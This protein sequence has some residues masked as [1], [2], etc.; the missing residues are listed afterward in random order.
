[1]SIGQKVVTTYLLG[2]AAYGFYRGWNSLCGWESLDKQSL[3]MDRFINGV[4]GT[5]IFGNPLLIPV[6][7][8]YGARRVEK[9]LRGFELK[10]ED[11]QW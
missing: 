6:T 9:R 2:N 3:Y 4:A 1:M 7:A 10:K 11:Y 5:M 8:F